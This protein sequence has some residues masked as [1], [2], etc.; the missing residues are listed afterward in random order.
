MK[1]LRNEKMRRCAGLLHRSRSS[2][3]LKPLAAFYAESR[4]GVSHGAFLKSSRCSLQRHG[5]VIQE[6]LQADHSLKLTPGEATRAPP[7]AESLAS[8]A[9]SSA[10]QRV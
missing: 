5:V 2:P 9:L 7:Q 1:T 6:L 10:K 8:L 4:S 3:A